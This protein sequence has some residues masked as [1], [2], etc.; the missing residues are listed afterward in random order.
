MK[1]RRYEYSKTFGVIASATANSV[2]TKDPNSISSNSSRS[3]GA[4]LAVVPANEEVLTWD[5]RKGELVSR[6]KDEKCKFQVT[7]ICQ[8]KVDPDVFA[9]GYSDGS[10]RLWDRKSGTVVISF[11]GHRAAVTTMAFDGSGTRLASG[12]KDAHIIVWDLI[13]EVGLYRLKGHKGEIT[14]VEFMSGQE[15]DEAGED[16]VMQL[17]STDGDGWLVST[18][19]DT[20]IKLWELSTQHCIETHVAHAGECWSLAISPDQKG[21]VTAGNDG[22]LKVWAIDTQALKSR[23]FGESTTLLERGTIYRK[24]KDRGVT[25][26]FHPSSNFIATHGT[27]KLVEIFRI[28]TEDEVKKVLKRKRKR[29]AEKGK[30]DEADIPTDLASATVED[31]FVSYIVIH[32][33]G[34]VKSIDWATKSG[35]KSSESLYFLLSLTNNSL[36]YYSVAKPPV[37]EKKSSA[38]VPEYNKLYTVE[39]SGHRSDIRSLSLSSDDRMLA[40]ASNGSLKIWNVR[41]STCIRTFEC[42]Y[43]LCCSFLPRDKIVVVGTKSGTI[44]LFDIASSVLLETVPAHEGAIWSLQVHPDGKSLATASADKSAKFWDFEVVSEPIPGTDTKLPRLK[45]AHKRTLKINDDILSLRYTPSGTH[46][47]VSLLDNTVKIFFTD[48]L[49]QLHNLYGHKLPVLNMDISSDSRLLITCSADKNVKIWGL[50]FGDCH[51]SFFAHNDSIMAVVFEKEGHNFWSA[52]KDKLIKY[53][54]G[55]KF[56]NVMKVEGHFGE[57][58]ALCRGN[59]GNFLISASHDKSIRVWE[60]TDDQV[61]KH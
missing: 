49:K 25:I 29:K 50:D 46:L 18:S 20:F 56:E 21:C 57:I 32:A 23:Q 15:E 2:W 59:I 44:H 7:S 35:T 1:Y 12:A 10:I 26:T 45:L 22:E 52:S 38:E 36:E 30:V 48:T 4:G 11:N 37:K 55:D 51:K 40:S 14:K 34:K 6:W 13:A 19:K 53:W 54:D 42:E 24:S 61:G 39:A 27:D 28:R 8:S 60:Q 41:T 58:W 9:V 3:T 16:G 43:A 31:I 5:I 33:G 17:D 47:A